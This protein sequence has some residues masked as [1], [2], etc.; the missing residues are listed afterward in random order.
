MTIEFETQK[1]VLEDGDIAPVGHTIVTF[2]LD[3][4]L[5]PWLNVD[6]YT[7]FNGES[8]LE[9]EYEHYVSEGVIPEDGE[10]EVTY[11]HAGIIRELGE[12]NAEWLMEAFPEIF[13]GV[14]VTRA[15]SPKYYNFET[16]SFRATYTVD[17]TEFLKAYREAG[18]KSAEAYMNEEWRSRDGFISFIP[19]RWNDPETHLATKRWLAF[20]WWLYVALKGGGYGQNEESLFLHVA[21]AE[22]EAYSNN[23]EITLPETEGESHD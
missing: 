9:S 10:L 15:D 22:W 5:L 12:A 13:L 17:W 23:T 7:S 21:E 2:V 19:G 18:A 16:D 14:E 11:D 3:S 20:H 6:T 8:W 1:T 4:N